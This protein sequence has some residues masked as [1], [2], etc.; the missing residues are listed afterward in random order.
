M[1]KFRPISD[2]LGVNREFFWKRQLTKIDFWLSE[3]LN[4]A[5]PIKEI[6]KKIKSISQ[7][8]LQVEMVWYS[9]QNNDFPKMY[10]T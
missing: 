5:I 7:R 1:N 8:K 9:K 4:I 6:E 2:N 10:I 3:K